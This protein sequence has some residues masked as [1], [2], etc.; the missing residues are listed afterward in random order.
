MIASPVVGFAGGWRFV[1]DLFPFD[2]NE[3]RA[4][5]NAPNAA[6]IEMVTDTDD[7][8]RALMVEYQSGSLR[9]FQ[10]LYARVAPDLRRYLLHLVRGADRAEDM[11]QDTFLQMH[12]SRAAYNPAYA[13]RPW[14]FGLARNVFLMSQRALRRW[15]AVHDRC[16]EMPD[17]PV[18]PEVEKLGPMDEIRRCLASLAADQSEALLLHHEW[19]FNFEEI[20][21]MVGITSASARAR[22]SRGMAALRQALTRQE[23]IRA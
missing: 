20:A 1:T 3:R 2:L 14:M 22:A 4:V 23:G 5:T 18:P 11:L 12:R 21:G 15:S 10:T 9:A 17:F 6:K 16:A 7:E 19:G 8:L 13:V